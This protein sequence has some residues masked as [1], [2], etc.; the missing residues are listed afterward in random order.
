[1]HGVLISDRKEL[2]EAQQ[3]LELEATTAAK[4]LLQDVIQL[5]HTKIFSIESFEKCMELLKLNPEL[6]LAWNFRRQ[7]IS[8]QPETDR[9]GWLK[10]ELFVLN[11]VMM[12]L[13]MTKSYCLWN[14][15]RWLLLQ[16]STEA[17][18]V[19]AEELELVSKILNLDGRNFHAW[20]YRQ[21]LRV[22][23]PSIQLDDLE[24]SQHLIE[25]DFSNYSAWF[26]RMHA[27]NEGAHVD[28]QAELETVWNA[29]FTEPTDQSV[30]QYHDWLLE[31]YPDLG[32]K[33]SE[34][35]SELESIIS[36]R[37]SKYLLLSKIK[38]GNCDTNEIVETLMRIDPVRTGY[39]LDLLV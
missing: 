5:K 22:T 9:H 33:D 19:L 26:L 28:A 36:E 32:S 14:H 13:R 2:S 12:D 3:A 35:S 17:A 31:K 30:W 7:I 29:I 4:S 6:A 24:Y 38:Q 34:F 25:K 27:V 37:E 10:K 11:T 15:R 16:L 20:S 21:W 23:F 1:M 8:A 18:D 39:Y